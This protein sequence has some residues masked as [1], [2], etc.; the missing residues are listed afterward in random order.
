M[1]FIKIFLFSFTIREDV[2]IYPSP[3]FCTD[4][5]LADY[6]LFPPEKIMWIRDYFIL[7]LYITIQALLLHI[8][9]IINGV[10][11]YNNVSIFIVDKN[12]ISAKRWRKPIS[13]I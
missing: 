3:T 4:P 13:I 8:I 1:N 7:F 11:L 2:S 6:T 12:F 10:F 9:V 5:D